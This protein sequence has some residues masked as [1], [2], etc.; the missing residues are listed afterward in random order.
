[1]D[2]EK[3]ITVCIIC[4]KEKKIVR[5]IEENMSHGLCLW[6]AAL[7]EQEYRIFKIMIGMEKI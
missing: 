6:H 7:T 3:T 5:K 1:M 4:D 2:E